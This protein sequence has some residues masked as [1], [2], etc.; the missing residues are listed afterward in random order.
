MVISSPQFHDSIR[1]L[2]DGRTFAIHVQR[3]QQNVLGTVFRTRK[4][5]S[6]IRN[7]NKHGFSKVTLNFGPTSEYHNT[8]PAW[9]F[10]S[11]ACFIENDPNFTEQTKITVGGGSLFVVPSTS[12]FRPPETREI[13]VS[14]GSGSS[15]INKKGVVAAQSIQQQHPLPMPALS[16]EQSSS[17]FSKERILGDDHAT[18]QY[19]Q[20]SQM[21]A[22]VHQPSRMQGQMYLSH[23]QSSQQA[24]PQFEQY[25]P[26]FPQWMRQGPSTTIS[27]SSN[28]MGRDAQALQHPPDQQRDAH[29]EINRLSSS[30]VSQTPGFIRH[31]HP[32]GSSQSITSSCVAES[33]TNADQ[34]ETSA[35]ASHLTSSTSVHRQQASEDSVKDSKEEYRILHLTD[36]DEDTKNTVSKRTRSH[37]RS[38]APDSHE[39][40]KRP[41]PEPKLLCQ[42]SDTE[43]LAECQ[44]RGLLPPAVMTLNREDEQD[45]AG[46]D[47]DDSMSIP[48]LMSIYQSMPQT[49]APR[50]TFDESG[51]QQRQ[52]FMVQRLA[53]TSSLVQQRSRARLASDGTSFN[54]SLPGMYDRR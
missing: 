14:Y 30:V 3:F 36:D 44:R 7:L 20:P 1:W 26:V 38:N 51:Q 29:L 50:S 45:L 28:P 37:S 43:L 4:Y 47:V 39:K 23:I 2:S 34:R 54:S 35:S 46:E 17:S 19:Q 41:K 40:P 24:Q 31:S 15:S 27:S 21:Y 6:F 11:H 10:F 25:R 16:F 53:P 22:P 13:R 33:I 12:S 9:N 5:V 52:Q 48:P 49:Q 42:F 8:G 18:G 32:M